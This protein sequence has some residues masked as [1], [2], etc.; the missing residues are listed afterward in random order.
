MSIKIF[1]CGVCHKHFPAEYRCRKWTV[2]W[3][4]EC[5]THRRVYLEREE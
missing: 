1:R 5:K 2:G 4:P 3:C